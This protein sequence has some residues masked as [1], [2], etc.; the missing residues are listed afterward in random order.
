[1]QA[2]R[3]V[4]FTGERERE[5]IKRWQERID[6]LPEDLRAGPNYLLG[7]AWAGRHDYEQAAAA[8]LWLPLV[9]DHDFRLAARACLEA[10]LALDR[11]GQHAESQTL[12]QEVATRFADTPFADEARAL[13]D[14]EEKATEA[15]AGRLRR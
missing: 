1:M 2:W 13:L 7:R 5:Q 11:I 14:H 6:E 12:L 9:D 8:L 4:A 3:E 15:S 10:A